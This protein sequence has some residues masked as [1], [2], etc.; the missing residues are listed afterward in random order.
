MFNIV[1]LQSTTVGST[2]SPSEP[3]AAE[4]PNQPRKGRVTNQLQYL[5]KVVMTQLWKHHFAWPFH[6]PVDPVKLGL[7]D[8][9]DIIKHPMDMTL[10]KKKLETNQYYSAKE[11]LQ[12]FN[13][14]FS[15][16]Y[17]YNKPTDDVVLMAQTLEKNFLQKIRDMPSEEFEVQPAV[18][19]K[20]KRGR[21]PRP[22]GATITR[23][24][25]Q[26]SLPP[27]PPTPVVKPTLP[28]EA[29]SVTST[30][31]VIPHPAFKTEP[32]TTVPPTPIQAANAHQA[33]KGVKRKA[34]T[35][36]PVITTVAG[37][38]PTAQSPEH[39]TVP[40]RVQSLGR[41]ESSGRTIRPPRSRDLD[42][43]EG[44][45][46][47]KRAKMGKMTEQVKY[48]NN[49]LKDF[50]SKKHASFAWP[51]YKSVDADLLGL[52]DYYDMIKNPMDLGTMR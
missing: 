28:D 6:L 30:N 50:F 47:G 4:K 10:I 26:D 23:K 32:Q 43:E 40:G 39:D 5:R 18:K 21:A 48:C 27:Q 41:R 24:Q 49:L 11:C 1:V 3:P 7:P 16:C 45:H 29:H 19:G 25:T 35:T 15:N 13:L 46:H 36:T 38:N 42:S 22:A 2:M 33:K 52:H 14:M 17:I 44:E 9:F 8:Y 37:K 20:G 34:D 51:F 12:D 31:D